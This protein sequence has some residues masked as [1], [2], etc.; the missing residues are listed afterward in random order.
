M[1]KKINVVNRDIIDDI[2]VKNSSKNQQIFESIQQIPTYFGCTNNAESKLRLKRMKRHKDLGKQ[3]LICDIITGT[4]T[5]QLQ[6]GDGQVITIEDEQYI[7][8]IVHPT[9]IAFI[10]SCI[11]CSM[12]Q[13][14]DYNRVVS[15]MAEGLLK[16][17][18]HINLPIPLPA[19]N[20]I[21]KIVGKELNEYLLKI[22]EDTG[23]KWYEVITQPKTKA[24]S[25]GKD[26]LLKAAKSS[27]VT[28]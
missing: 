19:D 6:S 23:T 14:D 12:T 13:C 15:A 28:T 9:I 7:T 2:V 26:L 16:T 18:K 22:C 1:S 11:A 8:T 27:D 24:K 21:Q 17:I 20:K 25:S 5:L 4:E 10:K 3:S